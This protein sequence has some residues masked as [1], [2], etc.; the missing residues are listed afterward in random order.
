[1]LVVKPFNRRLEAKR[2]KQ[3]NGDRRDM[4]EE[5]LP[6]MEVWWGACTS[7]IGAATSWVESASVF[8]GPAAFMLSA[9]TCRISGSVWSAMHEFLVR[10]PISLP[11]EMN[12][13][14]IATISAARMSQTGRER[15]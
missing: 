15:S 8:V 3:T 1:M 10:L 13:R 6:R 12:D 7:S 11:D 9:G 14:F 5:I 4:D 2:K